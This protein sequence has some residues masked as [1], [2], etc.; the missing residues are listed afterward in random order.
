MLSAWFEKNRGLR[1]AYRESIDDCRAIL[2]RLGGY[3]AAHMDLGGAYYRAGQLDEAESHVRQAIERGYPAP[4]VA[5]NYLACIAS[6]RRDFQAMEDHLKKAIACDPQHFVIV[7]NVQ[8][9]RTWYKEQGPIK[10]LP[11]SLS[12]RHE[13][14]IL[15]RTAQ[16]SLPGPLPDDFAEWKPA[17]ADGARAPGA[18]AS[19]EDASHSS[20]NTRTRLKVVSSP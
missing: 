19:D 20:Q 4:G 13:F 10:N 6:E 8:A 2:E 3:H 17:A 5:Y 16:P 15:E 12:A 14:Q 9:V 7:Q 18:R 1:D 11:L